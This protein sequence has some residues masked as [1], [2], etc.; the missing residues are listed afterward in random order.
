MSG[1]KIFPLWYAGVPESRLPLSCTA[2]GKKGGSRTNIPFPFGVHALIENI[3]AG[4]GENE[5]QPA[6]LRT[7][8]IED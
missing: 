8:S 4:F 2:K 5:T 3:S 1:R 6:E 7:M